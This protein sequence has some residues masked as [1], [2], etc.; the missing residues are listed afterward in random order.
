MLINSLAQRAEI[1]DI[2]MVW[3]KVGRYLVVPFG[4]YF[5]LP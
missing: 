3:K 1:Y 5:W 4:Y 2:I